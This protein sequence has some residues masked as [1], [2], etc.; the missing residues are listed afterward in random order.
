ME[1]GSCSPAPVAGAGTPVQM[2]VRAF[3][4]EQK[5]GVCIQRNG[6][7]HCFTIKIKDGELPERYKGDEQIEAAY[8]LVRAHY[9]KWRSREFSP[10]CGDKDAS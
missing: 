10:R 5:I 3:R 7:S 4:L 9:E 6:W 2:L 1:E 8:R